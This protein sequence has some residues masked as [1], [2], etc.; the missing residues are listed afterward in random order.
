MPTHLYDAIIIG[1]GHNGLVTA[2][3]LAKAGKKVLVLE[4]RD[5]IGG[6]AVTEEFAPGF[7]ASP[8]TD[9]CGLLTPRVVRDLELG[10][11]GLEIHPLDPA[12]FLPLPDGGHLT[13]WRDSEK[14]L[15]EIE[16]HS[17]ADAQTY[18]KFAR[19]I[20]TL[21]RCLRPALTR[22]APRPNGAGS[23]DLMEL[24]RLGWGVRRMGASNMHQLLRILPMSIADLMDEWFEADALKAALASPGIEG[25]G[26]STRAAGSSAVFLYHHLG[27][28][29]WPLVSWGL[30]RG[31]MGGVTS[32]M[33]QAARAFGAEIRTGAP[34]AR[35]LTKNGRASGVA[36]ANGDEIA[37]SVVVSN[38]DPRTTFLGLL[39]PTDLETDFILRV[40]RIRYRGVCAKINLALG[41]LPNFSSLPGKEPAAHHRGLI[42]IGPT[43]DYLERAFDDSKYGRFSSKPF[44]RVTIPSLTDPSLAPPGRHV[45]SIMMQYAPYRL[46][47]ENWGDRREALGDAVVDTLDEYAPKLKDSVLHRQVLTPP[48]LEETYGLPEGSLHHGDLALDQLFFMRPV[49]GWARYGTPVPNLYLC[50]S[51]THP[52]GGISG[53]PGYNASR[54]ILRDWGNP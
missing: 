8:T 53:A 40:K 19:L 48:D 27:E 42:Q 11:H 35:I 43:M 29:G 52:G 41:E 33:A 9:L 36:L 13:I 18:P 37:A 5:V 39:D 51:G 23:A 30:P 17:K 25:V 38:A 16:R 14:T 7:K 34:V 54:Q 49:P 1:A 2:A 10:R 47:D 46:R 15:R 45:M 26:L 20:Q 28:P 31:G 12:V 32:A 50:G 22:P 21:A 4:R 24:L 44:L 3:Y 6:A